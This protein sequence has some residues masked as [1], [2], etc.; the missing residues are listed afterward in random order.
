[1]RV[2]QFGDWGRVSTYTSERQQGSL[3]KNSHP[4]CFKT[5]NFDSIAKHSVAFGH[6]NLNHYHYSFLQ[7]LISYT[8]YKH[9]KNC[10]CMTKCRAAFATGS[11]IVCVEVNT[12]FLPQYLNKSHILTC[13]LTHLNSNKVP[14]AKILTQN[15]FKRQIL[16]YS[17]ASIY[18]Q[19]RC[20]RGRVGNV[21]NY[22]I[23]NVSFVFSRKFFC[24]MHVYSEQKS[25]KKVLNAKLPTGNVLKIRRQILTEFIA[26]LRERGK[27]K[28]SFKLCNRQLMF[29]AYFHPHSSNFV[30]HKYHNTCKLYSLLYLF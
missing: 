4:K 14:R 5:I 12:S 21:L 24:N 8:G 18:R 16:T 25:D 13:I 3:C 26:Q 17:I 2:G 6:A 23:D 19:Q 27:P 15:V 7:K 11:T 9:R 20:E 30:S 29:L 28:Y 10:I 1:M 22:A